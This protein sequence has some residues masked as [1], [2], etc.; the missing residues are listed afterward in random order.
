M[1]DMKET[2]QKYLD[3]KTPVT[4][5]SDNGILATISNGKEEI[6]VFKSRI[7]D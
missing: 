3:G 2:T 1:R 4:I 7:T 5:V 6:T